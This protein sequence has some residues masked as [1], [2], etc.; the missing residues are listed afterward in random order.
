MQ[1]PVTNARLLQLAN[2]DEA[3]MEMFMRM[4][5]MTQKSEWVKNNGIR[6]ETLNKK[7]NEMLKKYF[8]ID[9]DKVKHTEGE[10]PE[11]VYLEGMNKEDYEK[12][13][14]EFAQKE[15]SMKI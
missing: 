14:T 13:W 11:P 7:K 1:F 6:I 2:D 9:G 8:V 12:E 4:K 5:F 3:L 10:K 15:N